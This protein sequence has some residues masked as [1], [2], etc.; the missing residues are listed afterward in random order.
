MK[1]EKIRCQT[2][3]ND[4]IG[5][6]RNRSEITDEPILNKESPITVEEEIV[7]EELGLG[8]N[9]P[10]GDLVEQDISNDTNQQ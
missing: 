3:L 10:L 2:I 5:L 1:K 9:P 8:K 4:E 6:G 7:L